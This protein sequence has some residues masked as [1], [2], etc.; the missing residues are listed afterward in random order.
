VCFLSN[1]LKMG[2]F[3]SEHFGA[4]IMVINSMVCIMNV[5]LLWLYGCI[6]TVN[7]KVQYQI[8]YKFNKYCIFSN[9]IRT[10]VLAIS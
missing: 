8:G 7:V 5:V 2:R 9:L 3:K 10:Q 1:A 6:G 4:V